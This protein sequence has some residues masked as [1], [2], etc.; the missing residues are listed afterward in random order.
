MKIKTFYC[1]Q[2]CGFSSQKWLGKCPSC[3]SW[4]TLVEEQMGNPA[5]DAS[6]LDIQSGEATWT[7]LDAASQ[8]TKTERFSTGISELDRVL[9]GGVVRDGFTLIGGDPG[10]GKSTL[11]LQMAKGILKNEPPPSILYVSGEESVD[12]IRSRA[13]RL[14]IRGE[15][16]IYLASETQLERVFG[17]IHELKPQVLIM[18]SLQT[19]SSRSLPST[20]GSVGQLREV[21]SRLMVLAKS[22]NTAVWLVGHV[23]KDGS[24]AGLKTVE[25]M[26]DTVLY[27]EGE[28]GQVHRLLRTV[29][30][31]FGNTFELGVFEMTSEG[32]REVLNPS[33][34]FLSE[35]KTAIPGT[36]IGTSLE[37]TR[38]IFVE[39]QALVVPSGLALPRRT[40]VG[41]DASKVALLAAI[42]ERHT[43]C[44]LA[45]HDL[46]FNVAGGLKISEPGCDLAACAS[47]WSSRENRAI[48]HDWI[49]LGEVGLTGEVRKIPQLELRLQE[50]KKLGFKLAVIPETA[51]KI[52]KT[53]KNDAI[54]LAS[55][56]HIAS[57]STIL[58]HSASNR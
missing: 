36:A 49:W 50:A 19:F 23:T 21:A 55:M 3:E 53:Q 27:F 9:G 2:N 8:N 10:I 28:G 16:K 47:I 30:N 39:L 20:P 34:L 37:G 45:Q 6:P 57:L 51:I 46:F 43:G 26:V 25:H 18:D 1:C 33:S 54:Q 12:Q 31:R 58:K 17:M 32:L 4:N 11:L 48:P 44:N 35:R 5:A 52:L 15:H 7:L 41:L 56:D 40:A 29:K 13:L 38:P 14:G 22:S 42:L 24:I